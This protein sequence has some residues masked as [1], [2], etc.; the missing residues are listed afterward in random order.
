MEMNAGTRDAVGILLQIIATFLAALAYVWQKQAHMK[1]EA[2]GPSAPPTTSSL[3]WRMGFVLMVLVAIIDVY[4]FSLLDQ[5]KL[6]AFGA[7][8]LAWNVVLSYYLLK[9]E[10]TR[11]TLSSV[12]L[13]AVG[14]V[15]AVSSSGSSEEFKLDQI[16]KLSQAAQ[17]A[18]WCTF[19]GIGLAVAMY[20]IEKAVR[21]PVRPAN[22]DA[23]LSVLSPVAGGM[24]MGF[25][26]WGAKAISTCIFDGE[27]SAFKDYQIYG[28]FVL[29]ALALTGQVR[30]L[31]KGLEYS[32]AM[33][34]VPV[35]QASIICSNSVGGIIFYGDL[36]HA[37]AGQKVLFGLGVAIA[38]G[39]VC[40]L[41]GRSAGP[42]S[43]SSHHSPLSDSELDKSGRTLSGDEES[44][45]RELS[46]FAASSGDK[47]WVPSRQPSQSSIHV[48]REPS[49]PLLAPSSPV[50]SHNLNLTDT[51]KPTREGLSKNWKPWPDAQ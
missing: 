15:M 13:I 5:S 40:L 7:V 3:L 26:G 20:T 9:E 49:S 25:T 33:K 17:V 28:F 38:V 30:Y 45:D 47:R 16:I 44:T 51:G 19:N 31:N 6:G 29:V 27:W 43:L 18:I 35:F 2:G 37:S 8:T 42:S 14:T 48:T 22:F 46:S 1:H 21:A 39:G 50:L 41:L 10:L 4:S 12:F 32:D 24:C 34:V 23:I 11:L 36:G